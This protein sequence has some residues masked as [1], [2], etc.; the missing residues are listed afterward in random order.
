MSASAA[1][2]RATSLLHEETKR[3]V[4]RDIIVL[5][6]GTGRHMLPWE[7]WAGIQYVARQM[8]QGEGRVGV[9]RVGGRQEG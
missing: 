6:A 5:G 8:R 7:G 2:Q 3:E 4:G 9:G 1:H